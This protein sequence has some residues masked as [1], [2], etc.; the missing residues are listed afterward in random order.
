MNVV[1]QYVCPCESGEV[2]PSVKEYAAVDLKFLLVARLEVEEHVGLLRAA[3][4]FRS[5]ARAT[6]LQVSLVV[7]SPED[8]CSTGQPC[9][10]EVSNLV[11]GRVVDGSLQDHNVLETSKAFSR[12]GQEGGTA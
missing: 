5:V 11:Q 1:K 7:P 8:C 2:L 3:N 6:G 4:S 12:A 10:W 9:C